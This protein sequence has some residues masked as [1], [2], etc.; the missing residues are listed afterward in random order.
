MQTNQGNEEKKSRKEIY[1]YFL[2][3]DVLKISN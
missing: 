2:K 1:F 3:Y